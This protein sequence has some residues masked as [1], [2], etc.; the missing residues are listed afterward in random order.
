MRIAFLGPP[1]VGKGT[2]AVR[3]SRERSLPH[4]STGDMLREAVAAGTAV[5]LEAKKHMDAGGLVPDAVVV[6]I[7]EERTARAD[8]EKGFILDGFPRTVVQAEVLEKALAGRGQ[9]L[10][11]VVFIN[12]PDAVLVS[13][14][15]GRRTCRACGAIFHVETLKPKRARVCD[16][17]GGELVQREDDRPETVLARL[18]VYRDR[19][20]ALVEYYRRQGLLV[21]V[22]GENDIEIVQRQL[23]EALA[24]NARK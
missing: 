14:L 9:A 16:K 23:R 21:E 10:D 2:Q 4:I 15:S 7:V 24:G 5:G 22:S 6:K 3:L 1:G 13:R 17:C 18:R 8:C 11:A 19:T 12:A 20:A